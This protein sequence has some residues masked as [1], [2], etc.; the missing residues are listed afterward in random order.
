M[1][2]LKPQFFPVLKQFFLSFVMFYLNLLER[3]FI[4]V[5]GHLINTTYLSMRFRKNITKDKETTSKMKNGG[6]RIFI[7]PKIKILQPIIIP[8]SYVVHWFNNNCMHFC[9]IGAKTNF[10]FELPIFKI[11]P[12]WHALSVM[13]HPV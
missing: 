13:E 1:K 10:Q 7:L 9:P 4:L 12:L 2:I 6:S 5:N 3:H 11:F 8:L